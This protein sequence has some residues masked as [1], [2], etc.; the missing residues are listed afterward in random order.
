MEV[1]PLKDELQ[2]QQVL[3]QSCLPHE[4]LSCFLRLHDALL[5]LSHEVVSHQNPKLRVNIPRSHHP[6]FHHL[7][8]QIYHGDH[9]D[10]GECLKSHFHH[11]LL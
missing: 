10:Y 1:H 6:L 8:H 5:L 9:V 7:H 4:F 2:C 3:G 11:H